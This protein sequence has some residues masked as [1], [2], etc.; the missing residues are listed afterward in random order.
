MIIDCHVHIAACTPGHGHMSEKL[1]RSAAFRFMQ[2]RFG[3]SGASECTERALE[4]K[5]VETMEQSPID[6]AVVLAFDAA[7]MHDAAVDVANT[8]L[9]VTNSYVMQLTAKYPSMLFG[10]SV[11]P[12]RRDAI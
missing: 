12:Y 5:L 8:H 9:Y 7:Y 1:L 11:H 6:K 2:W 10:V 4:R 3:I